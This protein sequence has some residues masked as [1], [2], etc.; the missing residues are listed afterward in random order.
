M[1]IIKKEKLVSDFAEKKIG[2]RQTY[3]GVIQVGKQEI[4][5]IRYSNITDIDN[6]NEIY[7]TDTIELTKYVD[8]DLHDKIENYLTH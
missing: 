3:I 6:C 2:Y 4:P 7:L 1:K 5:Y 8:S